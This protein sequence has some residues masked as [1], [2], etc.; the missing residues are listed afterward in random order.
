[1]YT[2]A[3]KATNA[4]KRDQYCKAVG[5]FMLARL[6]T[7]GFDYFPTGQPANINGEPDQ[8]TLIG[9]WSYTAGGNKKWREIA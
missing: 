8:A 3:E 6:S 4:A 1:M 7:G 2:T 5:G 9:K